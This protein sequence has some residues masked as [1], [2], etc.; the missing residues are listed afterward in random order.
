MNDETDDSPVDPLSL[1]ENT[2]VPAFAVTLPLIDGI[3]PIVT[4]L[5]MVTDEML[6]GTV[7]LMLAVT[8]PEIAG[9][10]KIGTPPA[11]PKPKARSSP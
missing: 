5:P 6:I 9:R 1:T 11:L 4:E 8:V 10:D 2:P 7:P 3:D